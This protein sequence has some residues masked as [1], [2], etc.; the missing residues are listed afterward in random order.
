MK[1]L[2]L[3]LLCGTVSQACGSRVQQDENQLDA[4]VS[5]PLVDAGNSD[6]S[7][8]KTEV[9]DVAAPL[10]LN[11]VIQQLLQQQA[12]IDQLQ[13]AMVAKDRKTKKE[14]QALQQRT[15]TERCESGVLGIPSNGLSSGSGTRYRDLTATFSRRF[16]TTPVVT[17]GLKKLHSSS[18]TRVDT[19]V[20][21]V[22]PSHMIVRIGTWSNTWVYSASVY[23]MAC[24]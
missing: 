23:W 12:V 20:R 15:Y 22:Y 9:A 16:Q 6:N 10:S 5:S 2:L 21:S 3:I 24:A 17:V 8:N 18:F 7:T 13:T 14:I 11:D 1:T 4:Q 19:S